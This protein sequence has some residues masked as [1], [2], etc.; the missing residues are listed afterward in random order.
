MAVR[1]ELV[2]SDRPEWG[3]LRQVLPDTLVET[4]MWMFEVCL[5]RHRIH[6]YK[7]VVTRRYVHL[8]E[9]GRA[10]VYV[11]DDRYARIPVATALELA[12]APWWEE[13]GASAEETAAA[14]AAIA[15]ARGG[16]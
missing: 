2:Q 12:L 7:H 13:L 6:A 4:F 16:R 11:D 14:W 8:S 15:A 5:G 1:G 3:P 9:S 10:Y